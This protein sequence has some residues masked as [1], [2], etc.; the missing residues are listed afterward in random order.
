MMLV[1]LLFA[2]TFSTMLTALF[3]RNSTEERKGGLFIGFF[4]ALMV[5]AWAA[6]EW[7]FPALAGGRKI[8]W[9]PAMMLVTF[10]ALFASSLVLS[11]RTHRPLRQG[12]HS[13]DSRLGAEAAIFD[14]L[15]WFALLIAGIV[16]MR[17][18]GI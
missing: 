15:L 9:P 10:G 13:L 14:L 3:S 18:A 8:T 2:L 1:Y 17:S 12:T 16:L 6:D 4:A 5:L 11:V 7:L